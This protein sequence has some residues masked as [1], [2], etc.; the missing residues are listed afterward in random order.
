MLGE[1]LLLLCFDF[2]LEAPRLVFLRV[3]KELQFVL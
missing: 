2:P 3:A 1:E